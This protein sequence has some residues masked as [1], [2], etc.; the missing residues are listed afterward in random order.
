MK[1][2]NLVYL[3]GGIIIVFVVNIWVEHS[4]VAESIFNIF[5]YSDYRVEYP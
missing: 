5:E 2:L 4:T 1:K 3:I